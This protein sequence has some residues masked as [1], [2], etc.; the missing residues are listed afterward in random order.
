MKI[1]YNTPSKKSFN[2]PKSFTLDFAKDNNYS[3]FYIKTTDNCINYKKKGFI[4]GLIDGMHHKFPW[5]NNDSKKTIL[6]TPFESIEF[7]KPDF[8]YL[9]TSPYALNLEWNKA[10]SKL[11]SLL[12]NMNQES[13]DFYIGDTPVKVFGNYIQV[14]Y[15]IIPTFTSKNYFSSFDKKKTIKLYEV[16]TTINEIELEVAA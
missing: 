11:T 12:N 1:S 3:K 14:G 16:V 13:Y 9:Y 6:T 8:T 15:D 2:E 5:L 7:N 4:D 10:A